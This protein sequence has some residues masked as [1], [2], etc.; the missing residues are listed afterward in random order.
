M[1]SKLKLYSEIKNCMKPGDIIAF[2]GENLVSQGI[3]S[4][5]EGQISHV[6]VILAVELSIEGD[7]D[8]NCFN[9]VAE[10]TAEGVRIIS[11]SGLQRASA[12]QIG[13]QAR[14]SFSTEVRS[15][16]LASWRKS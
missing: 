1:S 8:H 2:S 12:L 4:V 6:G 15:S 11:L 9:L 3:K 10:A 13:A 14:S 5:T 7:P 16:D